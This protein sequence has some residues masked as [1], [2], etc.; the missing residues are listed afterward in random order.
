MYLWLH[1]GSRSRDS[2]AAIGGAPRTCG[3]RRGGARLRWGSSWPWRP[4]HTKTRH[5]VPVGRLARGDALPRPCRRCHF[6]MGRGQGRPR[7]CHALLRFS[8]RKPQR[9]L[10]RQKERRFPGKAPWPPAEPNQMG[11]WHMR[12]ETCRIE[13][14]CPYL[15][16]AERIESTLESCEPRS[17]SVLCVSRP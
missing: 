4:R 8:G 15:P 10:P 11:T 17:G 7:C 14:G 16:R 6:S 9:S 3:A 13:R 12:S 1:F 5:G 2:T